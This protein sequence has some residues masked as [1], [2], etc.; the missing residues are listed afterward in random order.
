MKNAK[1]LLGYQT[2]STKSQWALKQADEILIADDIEGQ[3][4]FGCYTWVAPKEE[5]FESDSIFFFHFIV[6]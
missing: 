2:S 4:H 6:D 3:R 1:I 5:V